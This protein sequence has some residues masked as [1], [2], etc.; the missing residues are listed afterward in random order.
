[1]YESVDRWTKLLFFFVKHMA[2][3]EKFLAQ[4]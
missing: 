3:G 1:M 4:L 2:V